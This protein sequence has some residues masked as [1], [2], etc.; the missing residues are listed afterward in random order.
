MHQ[1]RAWMNSSLFSDW[2]HYCFVPEVKKNLKELKLKKAILFMDN[3][4]AHP[5]VETLKAENITLYS[6][7][8]IQPPFCNR[9]TRALGVSPEHTLKRSWRKLA[10]YLE[11]VDQSNDSSSVTVTELNGLL[12]QIPGCGNCEEDEVS[13]WL[14]FDADDEGFQLM[15]DDEIIAQERKP[16]SNDNNSE[17][18][19]DE[20]IETSKISNSDAF[21]CLLKD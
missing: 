2:C 19:E 8:Q 6:G 9:W 10:P 5:D 17:S 13:S 1:E 18:D 3:A 15:C 20:V 7:H 11:N 4:P 16:N 21:E 12:K 14:D